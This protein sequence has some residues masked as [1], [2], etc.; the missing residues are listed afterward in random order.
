MCALLAEFGLAFRRAPVVVWEAVSDFCSRD[1][2][3]ACFAGTALLVS[4]SLPSSLITTHSLDDAVIFESLRLYAPFP[5]TL[6]DLS[7]A[8]HASTAGIPMMP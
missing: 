1:T 4:S 6:S 2:Q 5:N 7:C 3:R 8:V